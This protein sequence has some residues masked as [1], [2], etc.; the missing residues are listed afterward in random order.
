[1]N[2]KQFRKI[3]IR[4][5]WPISYTQA[6]EAFLEARGIDLEQSTAFDFDALVNWIIE[7]S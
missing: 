4:I 2:R 7:L 5:G 3:M 1:M 6:N